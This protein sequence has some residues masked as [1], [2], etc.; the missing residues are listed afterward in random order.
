LKIDSFAHISP[1]AFQ[2]RASNIATGVGASTIRNNRPV[3]FDL[4]RRFAVM[5]RYPDYRQI[6]TLALPAIEELTEDRVVACDLARLANDSMAEIVHKYPDR[7]AGFAAALPLAD[8]E[9]TLVEADRALTA[10]TALGVQI[11]TNANGVPMDDPRFEPLY[12][13]MAE[14][15]KPI[16]VHPTRTAEAADYQTE[17]RSRY[18]VFAIFGW[19]YETS[20]F[21]TRLIFSGVMDRYPA[22]HV[23][24][25]HAGGMVPHFAARIAVTMTANWTLE[26]GALESLPHQL[27]RPLLDYYRMFYGDTAMSGLATDAIQCAISFFGV[28]HIL[29]GTDAPY[30]FEE[31]NGY[32][33][34]LIASV[35]ELPVSAEQ[36]ERIFSK[37]ARELL[38][39]K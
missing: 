26:P 1:L 27:S 9:A 5:D 35:E 12:A 11:F 25:H 33:R 3:L 17:D 19:P 39:C 24:T 18:G 20:V 10:L 8:A 36:Q 28:D 4:D 6:I 30:G 32:I 16:W 13:R 31:G 15:G 23:L 34:D 22:L 2:E 7:F 37:N 38:G 14:M 21:M 29:F